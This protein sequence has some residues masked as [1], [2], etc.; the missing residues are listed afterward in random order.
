MYRYI[1]NHY[2][3]ELPRTTIIGRRLRIGHQAGIVIHPRAEIGDDC[4]IR[5][6]VT[7]GAASDERTWEAPKLE[8][9]VQIGCGAAI[10]GQITI[11]EGARVGP[12]AVVMTN[13]PAGA[14]VCAPPS[15]IIQLPESQRRGHGTRK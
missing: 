14:T 10:L 9:G 1:R 4:L 7:I 13:I 3:I 6:N 11:G 8:N 5:Q 12:N 15:R 2:G